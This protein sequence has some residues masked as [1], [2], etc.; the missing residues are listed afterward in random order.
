MLSPNPI[1]VEKYL[2]GIDYP[3]SKEDLIQYAENNKAPIIVL[4]MLNR[5]HDHLF[6]SLATVTK[7][8]G[9]WH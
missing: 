3:A 8:V 7:E 9:R 1:Q 4:S 6:N 5:L 2:R